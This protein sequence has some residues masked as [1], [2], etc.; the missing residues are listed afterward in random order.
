MR[1][2]I[3]LIY[4]RLLCCYH[5]CNCVG[6]VSGTSAPRYVTSASR[7]PK[8]SSMYNRGLIPRNRPLRQFRLIWTVNVGCFYLGFP[9]AITVQCRSKVVQ[10][11]PRGGVLCFIPF[12]LINNLISFKNDK[13]DLLSPSQRLRVCLRARYLLTW[14]YMLHFL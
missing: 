3:N 6:M 13:H 7:Y 5:T 14:N 1:K 8:R 10:N 12:H 2:G 11:A 9:M 4:N